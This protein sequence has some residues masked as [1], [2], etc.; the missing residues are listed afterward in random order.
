MRVRNRKLITVIMKNISELPDIFGYLP[1]I[2]KKY[3]V[4]MCI[5]SK[6]Q[7]ITNKDKELDLGLV[8][9]NVEILEKLTSRG[10]SIF[11]LGYM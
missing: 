2:L 1:D 5:L 11:H 3:Q 8:T 9:V 10:G 7:Q 6:Q 4:L